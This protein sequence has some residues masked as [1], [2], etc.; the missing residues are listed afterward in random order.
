MSLQMP[1]LRHMEL[2]HISGK[3]I[4]RLS[5]VMSK[6]RTAPL[7]QLTLPKLELKAAALAAKD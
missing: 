3:I 5:L 1:A 6:S 7:K 4:I 2:Q